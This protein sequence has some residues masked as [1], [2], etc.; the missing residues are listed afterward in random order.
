MENADPND[1]TIEIIRHASPA[2]PSKL[3]KLV[4]RADRA[5]LAK[6]RWRGTAEDGREFGFDLESPL[7]DGAIFFETAKAVYV[8]EQLPE[9]VFEVRFEG[10]APRRAAEIGWLFGNLHFPIEITAEVIRV[11]DDAAVKQMLE[12]EHIPFVETIAVFHP[13]KTGGGH[14]HAH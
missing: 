13:F 6:R 12:R 10:Q 8:I 5:T 3:P 2:K 9:P 7:E 14:H 4:L 1:V 11:A